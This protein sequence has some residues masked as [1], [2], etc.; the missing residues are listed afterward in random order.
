MQQIQFLF[1]G[2]FW[3]VLK[4]IFDL[5][6]GW[7]NPVLPEHPFSCY[8]VR[9]NLKNWVSRCSQDSLR[10]TERLLCGAV[11]PFSFWVKVFSLGR[12]PR[13]GMCA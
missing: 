8:Q 2:T 4:N 7:L 9:K 13:R 11:I 5:Q 3:K 10:F 6:L 12:N 1:W